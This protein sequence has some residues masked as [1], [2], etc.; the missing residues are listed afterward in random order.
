MN[1]LTLDNNELQS[2]IKTLNNLTATAVNF[3]I[4]VAQTALKQSNWKR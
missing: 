3:G 4:Q 2:E 1:T